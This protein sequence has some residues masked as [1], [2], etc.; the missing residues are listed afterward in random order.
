VLKLINS[1]EGSKEAEARTPTEA[2]I[3]PNNLIQDRQTT[4]VKVPSA[5]FTVADIIKTPSAAPNEAGLYAWWFDE[6]PKVPLDAAWEQEGFRL[7]Y[8]GI[9]SSRPGSRRT[10]RQRLRN[11]CSGPIATSTLRR[12]LAAVLID[13]LELHPS[14]GPGKKVKLPAEE[15]SRL[16][17]WLAV[18]GRVAWITHAEPWVSEPELLK[19]GPPLALNIRGNNHEFLEKLLALRKQ[20]FSVPNICPT[21][22]TA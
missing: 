14:S 21:S 16:S 8:V 1:Q 18:H 20:L 10:L 19:S 7:A 11:H 15:E 9:A 17:D 6:L 5:L 4:T 22:D 3:G 2:G 12:S 13:L